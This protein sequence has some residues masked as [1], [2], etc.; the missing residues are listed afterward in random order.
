MLFIK[1]KR[2]IKMKIKLI[3]SP[4]EVLKNIKVLNDNIE[5]YIFGTR[6]EWIQWLTSTVGYDKSR[7]LLWIAYNEKEEPKGYIVGI[8]GRYPPLT[9][10]LIISYAY[11]KLNSNINMA[12]F[13]EV[14]KWAKK[15]NIIK[16][17]ASTDKPEKLEKYGFKLGTHVTV[18]LNL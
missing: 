2:V 18:E 17:V 14:K 13:N 4:N 6:E 16:I 15:N 10:N 1:I 7:I 8:D 9:Y 3:D 12:L 11:S 5:N